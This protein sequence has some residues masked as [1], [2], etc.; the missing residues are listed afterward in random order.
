MAKFEG[1]LAIDDIGA[2]KLTE[3]VRQITYYILNEREQRELP[4]LITSNFSLMEIDEMIDSRISS[5][6]AGM[7]EVIKLS[8]KDR[9]LK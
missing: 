3:F 5:R 4:T 9:R 7:C 8:G 6:I 2:E 1:W